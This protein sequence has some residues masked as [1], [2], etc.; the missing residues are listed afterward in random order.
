M[1]APQSNA[2]T[3]DIAFIESRMTPPF[4]RHYHIQPWL[5]AAGIA[6][7]HHVM[8]PKE[9]VRAARRLFTGCG[10]RNITSNGDL[11]VKAVIHRHVRFS[12]PHRG[13]QKVKTTRCKD[14]DMASSIHAAIQVVNL[15]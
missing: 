4:E 15:Q 5:L 12:N 7:D 2:E 3:N 10:M 14:G 9:V 13:E 6:F 11:M 1:L 8:S